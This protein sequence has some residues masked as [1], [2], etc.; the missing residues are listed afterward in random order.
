MNIIKFNKEIYNFLDI[1]SNWL[2]ISDLSKLHNLKKYDKFKRKNDQ[3]TDWH[4][5]FY[6]KIREDKI[7]SIT[8]KKF[9]KEIIK[10]RFNEDIVY[11]K[12]PTFRVHL[13]GNIAVGEFHKDKFYRNENWANK[14]KEINYFFPLTRA[15]GT[16][17][18]W[19]E[20]REDKADFSP[21][22]VNY[23]DCVEWD[24]SNLM[25]GNKDNTTGETRVS[26]D[27]RII[28]ISRY[29]DSSHNTINTSIPFSIGGYYEII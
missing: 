26:F 13:P 17:T 22:E 11:Q 21:I 18:I 10:P 6:K 25:H 23:G 24:A 8:Y 16:N 4:R 14:V 27:F 2:N 9:L 20:S 29:V 1:V 5:L 15:Y 7:F 12:I 28:P 19:V 3:S